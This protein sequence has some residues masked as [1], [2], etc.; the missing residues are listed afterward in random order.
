MGLRPNTNFNSIQ[1]R[2]FLANNQQEIRK[3]SQRLASGKRIFT[4]G[5]DAAGMAIT[6][7]MTSKISSS[8]QAIRNATDAISILQVAEGSLSEMSSV[9]IRLRELSMQ[10]S[11]DILTNEAREGIDVEFQQMKEQIQL[12]ALSAK[13]NGRSI[14]DGTGGPLDVQIGTGNDSFLDR[15]SLDPQLMDSTLGALGIVYTNAATKKDAQTSL[16]VI[17]SAT[18]K[19]GRLRAQ[20]GADQN[21]LELSLKTLRNKVENLSASRSS[22]R[23]AD[24][25][26]EASQINLKNLI[27]ESNIKSLNISNNTPKKFM[28]LVDT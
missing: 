21:R 22:M 6:E 3:A 5:D 8:N 10:S 13:Y 25:I 15:L 26:T 24:I 4:A 2:R 18:D 23:D 11:N 9:L 14:L 20:M 27:K 7:M 12:M 1:G 17:D 28:K 19:L 16:G